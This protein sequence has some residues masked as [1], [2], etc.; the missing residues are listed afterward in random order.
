M[1]ERTDQFNVI[2]KS[3]ITNTQIKTPVRLLLLGDL[4]E[5]EHRSL[6]T[7]WLVQISKEEGQ[8]IVLVTQ[9]LLRGKGPSTGAMLYGFCDYMA[10]KSW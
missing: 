3:Q 6:A 9:I 1:W 5:K 2:P 7:P 4:T 10:S 8:H